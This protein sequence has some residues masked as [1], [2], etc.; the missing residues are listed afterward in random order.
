MSSIVRL[1]VALVAFFPLAKSAPAQ[2]L[3]DYMHDMSEALLP[4]MMVRQ[5]S[6]HSLML[7]IHGPWGNFAI[8]DGTDK[9][10][11]GQLTWS[12]VKI[13]IQ[14]IWID[15]SKLDEDKIQNVKLFSLEYISKHQR[16]TPYVADTHGITLFTKGINNEMTV[17]N[18]DLDKVHALEG[19]THLT[20]SQL[21]VGID[22]RKYAILIFK[23]QEHADVFQ[24]AIQKAIVICKAQ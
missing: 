19:Q 12:V 22:E 3:D 24:K 7:E 5:A 23:D 18:V 6:C 10:H 4:D 8:P 16:G 2:K 13:D 14:Q 9:D 21:G 15:L 1:C 11:P 17:N 20:D